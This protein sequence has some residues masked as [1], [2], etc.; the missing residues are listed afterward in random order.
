MKA[1]NHDLVSLL[2][3]KLDTIQ[4]LEGHCIKDAEEAKCHSLPALHQILEEEKKH[5]QMLA[6]EIR[7]RADAGV[8]D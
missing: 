3:T 1:I 5:A 7:M 8:F 2:K 6:E 4:A